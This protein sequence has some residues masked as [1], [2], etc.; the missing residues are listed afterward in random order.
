MSRSKA[1]SGA[2]M[3]YNHAAFSRPRCKVTVR[4]AKRNQ[5]K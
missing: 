3:R 4:A 2:P 1:T 5:G